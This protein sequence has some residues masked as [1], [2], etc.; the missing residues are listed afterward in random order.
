MRQRLLGE[1][2]CIPEEDISGAQ[3]DDRSREQNPSD[4]AS[5]NGPLLDNSQMTSEPDQMEGEPS[6]VDHDPGNAST[7]AAGPSGQARRERFGHAGS[8][9]H[10]KRNSVKRAG[11]GKK[12][13][14]SSLANLVD[15]W[16]QAAKKDWDRE[17]LTAEEEKVRRQYGRV[18]KI[19]EGRKARQL[20]TRIRTPPRR[21]RSSSVS[22]GSSGPQMPT[23]RY[24]SSPGP[25]L[26]PLAEDD[27]QDD[28]AERDERIGSPSGDD[29]D[30]HDE[31][32][33]N[34]D[35]QE[36]RQVELELVKHLMDLIVKLE[37]EARQMLLD[38]MDKTVA[39]TLL[40]ADRNGE[41]GPSTPTVNRS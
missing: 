6:Q 23:S 2:S 36:A 14:Q 25:G 5:G 9:F 22:S 13:R 37:A 41:P 32:Q 11:S 26:E 38:S 21:V 10:S 40:L 31:K 30:D 7:E 3:K 19:L 15:E 12:K 1:P 24:G 4:D 17:E 35:E 16:N 33:R 18:M 28:G 29:G 27:T 8:L 39:R 34:N 20:K